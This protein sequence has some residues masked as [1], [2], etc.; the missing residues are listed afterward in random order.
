MP[1]QLPITF[2]ASPLTPGKAYTPQQLQDAIVARLKIDS[3]TELSFFTTGTTAPTSNTG[4]WLKD[5]S[6]WYV[7]DAVLGTYVPETL[8]YESLRY[9][10]SE[11][12]PDQTT[13]TLWVKLDSN[14]KAQELRYYSGGA[15]RSVYDDSFLAVLSQIADVKQQYPFGATSSAD[16]TL[17]AAGD[18]ATV[19]FTE[20]F[21]PAG[22]FDA[23]KFVV[24][25]TG[26]Y[27]INAKVNMEINSG[28]PTGNTIIVYLLK[29]GS[30]NGV[31][32]EFAT[33]PIVDGN[34][35]QRTYNISTVL[36]LSAND[37]ISVYVECSGTG[38]GDWL[39]KRLGTCFSGHRVLN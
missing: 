26:Y 8:T 4:P 3:Q 18:N 7:W 22:V 23:S 28:T 29:N 36:S 37:S 5:G 38:A 20:T 19:G 1:S 34:L 21:D 16:Q 10:A 31:E 39:I 33:I 14:G 12:T 32:N 35:G 24:P 27:Q 2:S 13:Y 11:S 25:A 17:T 6:T 15:W 30:T 9:I